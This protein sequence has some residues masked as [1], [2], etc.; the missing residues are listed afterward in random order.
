[1]VD[2]LANILVRILVRRNVF[3]IWMNLF[4]KDKLSNIFETLKLKFDATYLNKQQLV[5]Q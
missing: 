3:E 4:Y 5:T 1:M 2:P